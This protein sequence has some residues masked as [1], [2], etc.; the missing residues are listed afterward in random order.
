MPYKRTLDEAKAIIQTHVDEWG[1][2]FG[3][4]AV[5]TIQLQYLDPSKMDDEDDDAETSW[6]AYYRNAKIVFHKKR[7]REM[8][9]EE[10]EALVIHELGHLLFADTWD[11]I[12]A[13]FGK[14]N[15]RDRILQQEEKNVDILTRIIM[16]YEHDKE[17]SDDTSADMD[18]ASDGS[19]EEGHV[20]SV[21]RQRLQRSES[22][23]GWEEE[24]SIL[25]TGLYKA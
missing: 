11:F 6:P 12:N 15:V 8:S 19:D 24:P 23:G 4:N 10:L 5:W 7:V 21:R 13:E 2:Y 14:G 18:T 22:A 25:R 1:E 9:E 20:G 3:L 17:S 16:R